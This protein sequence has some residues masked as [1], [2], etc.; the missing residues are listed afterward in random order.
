MI[1]L[2]WDHFFGVFFLLALSVL[3]IV[4]IGQYLVLYADK[5]AN[6]LGISGGLVGYVLVAAVTS[7]PELVSTFTAAASNLPALAAGNIYG[8]NTANIAF[9]SIIFLVTN[10]AMPRLS[11]E[12][13]VGFCASL[14]ILGAVSGLYMFAFFDILYPQEIFTA[15]FIFI[16]YLFLMYINYRYID[17]EETEAKK[18]ETRG[19]RGFLS[20]SVLIVICSWALVHFCV[21][22]TE[23]PFP[24]LGR[25]LGQQ[26]VGTLI[27]AV[28]TSVPEIVTTFAMVRKGYAG[29]AYGNI[30]GSNVFNLMIFC[31]APLFAAKEFWKEI[32][33]SMMFTALFV[34]VFSVGLLLASRRSFLRQRILLLGIVVMWVFSLALIF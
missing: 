14:A 21:R 25:P 8:S 6:K 34:V 17:D 28:A 18:K 24:G 5:L 30:F 31:F 3:A 33:F 15:G 13:F 1:A 4:F 19:W 2:F 7:I 11:I 27:L 29:M 16:L 20:F 23:L 26:F 9:L 12:S 22:M 10:K 32:P